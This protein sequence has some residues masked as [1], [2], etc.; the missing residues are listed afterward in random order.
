MYAANFRE[1]AR[2]NTGSHMLDS[3][4]I[5]GRHWQQPGIP[6]SQPLE[7]WDGSESY[8]MLMV[9]TAQLLDDHLYIDQAATR[10]FRLWAAIADPQDNHSWLELM[11]V[12]LDRMVA[13]GRWDSDSDGTLT[14]NSYNWETDLDQVFQFAAP[15]LY[16]ERVLIQ[17]HNGADVRGGYT[18]PVVAA[19]ELESAICDYNVRPFCQHCGRDADNMYYGERDGWKLRVNRQSCSVIC[20][21]CK[22][23]ARC[24]PKG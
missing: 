12:Y 18:A 16:G 7:Y 21:D 2:V 8:P 3:G 23:V 1:L 6:S 19:G 24:Y 4:G 15:S 9:S 10:H 17:M 20:P 14:D 13:T 5:Y 11:G 22:R